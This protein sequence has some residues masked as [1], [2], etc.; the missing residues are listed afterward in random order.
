MALI[1]R[2]TTN[3]PALEG[4]VW[5][6][7]DG[8]TTTFHP[9]LT[10]TT[11][12]IDT[13]GQKWRRVNADLAVRERRT[14][15]TLVQ[16]NTAETILRT[17]ARDCLTRHTEVVVPATTRVHLEEKHL[18]WK[19][20]QCAYY[21]ILITPSADIIF[22]DRSILETEVSHT[23]LLSHVKTPE[24][25]HLLPFN[26]CFFR[27]LRVRGN[28]RHTPELERIINQERQRQNH[29]LPDVSRYFETRTFLY[30][31]NITSGFTPKA[32]RTPL[33]IPYESTTGYCCPLVPVITLTDI[34]TKANA[35]PL[36]KANEGIHV[37]SHSRGRREVLEAMETSRLRK[38]ELK[39]E[40]CEAVFHPERLERIATAHGLE[41]ADYIDLI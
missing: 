37:H 40:L 7:H 21:G 31:E 41:V 27:D 6:N 34:N 2:N 5:R 29:H 25:P 18:S 4:S 8:I 1:Q 32:G 20:Y 24:T 3:V 11:F 19:P 14:T 28:P 10:T 12:F 23:T 16:S 9:A 39:R 36:P 30:T 35:K 15:R 13:S 38:C 17:H 26:G 33:S 22:S